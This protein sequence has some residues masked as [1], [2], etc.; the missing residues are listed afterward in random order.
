[1]PGTLDVPPFEPHPL[2]R[3]GHAQT[4]A[5]RYFPGPKVR[6]ESTTQMIALPDGARLSALETIP[7]G[8]VEGDPAAIMLHGLA[9]CARSSFVVRTAYR[10]VRAG[11]RTVRLN[12]RNAGDGF[13]LAKGFYHSGRTDDVRVVVEWLARRAPGSPI[14]LVGFSLG[15]NL[16]LK[17]A[18]EAASD[19]LDALDCIVAANPPIDLAACSKL[20]ERKEN[21]KYDRH[22]ARLL[23]GQV[24][25]LHG[26][27]PELGPIDLSGVESVRRFDERYTAPRNGFVDADDYY[28][29]SSSARILDRIQ[30]A[31][32]VVHATDDPF[33]PV[34][35]F[36][37][38]RFPAE[39]ELEL[40]SHGGHIGYL[41]KYQWD[42]DRR[43]LDKRLAAW[44][45]KR[46]K[47]VFAT[48][49][50]MC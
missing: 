1:M 14:A 26:C 9:G 5:G 39:V 24:E 2:L 19:P 41:S 4:I 15:G 43:W 47:N 44:L 11:V 38:A 22:F 21:Q 37:T 16:A 23:R 36:Q 40:L 17:L 32:L 30:I 3:G 35:P 48:R 27:F 18:A 49:A 10:L 34:E 20:L 6:L 25:R 12:M 50:A 7:A 46:W 33:I 42:G 45:A 28:E 29:R 13:G 31:G 8:W